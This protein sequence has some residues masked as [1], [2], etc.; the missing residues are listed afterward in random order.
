[1]SG[2]EEDGRASLAILVT[3]NG[4]V[5]EAALETSSPGVPKALCVLQGMTFLTSKECFEE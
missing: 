5:C 3:D 1:M 4:Y 2:Y